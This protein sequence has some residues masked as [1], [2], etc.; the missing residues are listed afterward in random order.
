MRGTAVVDRR[1]VALLLAAC[2]A[3][4]GLSVTTAPAARAD[5]ST[6][7]TLLNQSRQAAGLPQLVRDSRLDAVAQTWTASMASTKTLGHNPSYSTQIP[8]GWTKA[9]ENVGG[10]RHRRG[11]PPGLDEQRGPQGEHPRCLHLRRHRLGQGRRRR[12]WATQV[13]ATYRGVTPPSSGSTTLT[14]VTGDAKTDLV[15]NN[16]QRPGRRVPGTD[17][18]AAWYRPERFGPGRDALV[19]VLGETVIPRTPKRTVRRGTRREARLQGAV[20]P[21][22]RRQPGSQRLGGHQPPNVDMDGMSAT[23]PSDIR[24][25]RDAPAR[26]DE[27][28]Q[29][30]GALR[31]L[32]VRGPAGAV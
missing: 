25:P 7:Y 31:E 9:G 23:R 28:E 26:L 15:A 22:R 10:L 32:Q 1:V 17:G 8:S 5:A 13:F 6:L 11:H 19:P 21:G 12:I 29:R 3:A 4:I 30:R 14:D 20:P 27:P 18:F 16:P 2:L 24:M